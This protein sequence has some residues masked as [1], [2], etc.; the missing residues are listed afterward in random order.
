MKAK[1]GIEKEEKIVIPEGIPEVAILVTK[2]VID[3]LI[4]KYG[5]GDEKIR[6]LLPFD[7]ILAFITTHLAELMNFL[8][9]GINNTNV[10]LKSINYNEDLLTNLIEKV[11]KNWLELYGKALTFIPNEKVVTPVKRIY[12]DNGFY[13]NKAGVHLKSLMTIHGPVKYERTILASPGPAQLGIFSASGRKTV[14]PLDNYLGVNDLPNKMTLKTMSLCAYVAQESNSY[15]HAEETLSFH[16]N[17]NIDADTIRRVC[18]NLGK[19]QFDKL[20]EEAEEI[21]Q[22]RKSG[23][24][25]FGNAVN[26]R[27]YILADGSYLWAR[28]KSEAKKYIFAYKETKLA[29]FFK[30]SDIVRRIAKNGKPVEEI[31]NAYI[32]PYVG[33]AEQF[34]KL[35]YA[36][37]YKNGCCSYTEKIILA[38][39]AEM[40]NTFRDKYFPDS[41]RILDKFHLIE[42]IYDYAKELYPNDKLRREK[43]VE[44]VKKNIYERRIS[45]ALQ[46]ILLC[47]PPDFKP[48]E[49]V[50]LFNYIHNNR[51]FIDYTTYEENGLFV[52]SGYIES[53]NKSFVH[54]R[55]REPG[56]RWYM[57]SANYMLTLRRMAF[58]NEWTDFE[59]TIQDY[60]SWDKKLLFCRE[61]TA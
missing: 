23:D 30:E 57:D 40:F 47:T 3:G 37:L 21:D 27:V 48:K 59:A 58:N 41:L 24:L 26:D 44:N 56:M 8:I 34:F 10:N 39:G 4:T 36:A 15:K 7:E 14:C 46:Y 49:S 55:M 32:V 16:R 33:D 29:V 43:F 17:L 35:L 5:N 31:T 50:N 12:I 22:K 45:Q 42:R 54:R 25:K 52:G 19:I 38:D 61:K 2:L 28:F 60:Y 53:L 6:D 11:K 18:M 20:I 9:E 13:I 1:K 51:N